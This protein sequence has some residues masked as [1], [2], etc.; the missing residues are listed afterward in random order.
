MSELVPMGNA[1]IRIERRSE[2]EFFSHENP[3]DSREQG[4]CRYSC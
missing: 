1:L 3:D 2:K 4:V